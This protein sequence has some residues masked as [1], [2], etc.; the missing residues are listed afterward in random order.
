MSRRN[1]VIPQIGEV[2]L[3][4]RRGSKNIRISVNSR[5]QV[6]VGMPYWT[7]Y[8]AGLLFVKRN[9]DWI[10]QQLVR[11][12]SNPATDGSRIGKIHRVRLVQRPARSGSVELRIT[13]TTVDVK[14]IL[15]PLHPQI[16]KKILAACERALKQQAENLL[17]ARAKTISRKHNLSY[18]SLKIRK[19][20]S[21]WG[22]CSSKKDI[23]LSYYLMQLPWE[24]IDYVI[25]HELAHTVIPNHS[26]KFWDFMDQEQP[27]LKEI[28][29]Q[30]KNY[31]PRVEPY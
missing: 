18:R 10:L 27:N 19:L 24:F 4:K 1:F 26:R 25:L 16:Q 20:T 23:S 6:R 11:N 7:P 14:T 22:S 2:I 29:I 28:R 15:D 30:I 17:P 13:S 31:K 8:E 21:R 9:R 5:G 3:S 12:A